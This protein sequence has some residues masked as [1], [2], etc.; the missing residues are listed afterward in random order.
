MQTNKIASEQAN[1]IEYDL[2]EEGIDDTMEDLTHVKGNTVH[3]ISKHSTH[4]Q[5][6]LKTYTVTAT[7]SVYKL[8]T[9]KTKYNKI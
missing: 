7:K 5:L 8:T 3:Q 9:T 6:F 1:D 2:L 4:T